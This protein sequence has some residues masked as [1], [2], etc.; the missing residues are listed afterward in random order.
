MLKKKKKLLLKL[1]LLL[2][3]LLRLLVAAAVVVDD[4]V[5]GGECN[6]AGDDGDGDVA[7]DTG[8]ARLHLYA[9]DRK[10]EHQTT[11]RPRKDRSRDTTTR[12]LQPNPPP[13][14]RVCRELERVYQ[15]LHS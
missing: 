10:E 6:G 2:L 7:N 13:P 12:I 14:P 9:K 11:K 4:V 8:I 5:G 15:T 1:A 3:L